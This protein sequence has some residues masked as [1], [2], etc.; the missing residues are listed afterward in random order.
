MV[1]SPNSEALCV[2]LVTPIMSVGLSAKPD[3]RASTSRLRS[4]VKPSTQLLPPAVERDRR[5][6]WV[7][8]SRA[9]SV[10]YTSSAGKPG[11]V[12]SNRS[13]ECTSLTPVAD[14]NCS[15]L[16]QFLVSTTRPSMKRLK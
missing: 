8:N 7:S 3:T 2:T 12:A 6:S 5:V 13:L 10:R 16:S 15:P 11:T 1:P 14:S 4:S 9:S